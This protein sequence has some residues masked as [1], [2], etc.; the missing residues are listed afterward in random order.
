LSDPLAI[1]V[2]DRFG[3]QRL[4]LS[5]DP[6]TQTWR[7]TDEACRL[8]VADIVVT[9]QNPSWE[10]TSA[11]SKVLNQDV[12]A[13]PSGA[14]MSVLFC[15]PDESHWLVGWRLAGMPGEAALSVEPS[16]SDA[17]VMVEGRVRLGDDS[18]CCRVTPNADAD[19]IVFTADGPVSNR[20]FNALFSR[21]LDAAFEA[22]A[23]TAWLAPTERGHRLRAEAP[24]GHAIVLSLQEHFFR[25]V[26]PYYKPIDKSRFSRPAN[27]W[28][29]YYCLFEDPDEDTVLRIADF[30]EEHLVPFG[31][32]YFSVE[33]WQANHLQVLVQPNYWSVDHRKFPHGVKWLMDEIRARGLK[34][35][36]WAV[37]FG[38]GDETFHAMRPEIFLH[39]AEGKPLENWSGRYILDP[40]QTDA[41]ENMRRYVRYLAKEFGAEYLKLDG[42]SHWAA[43]HYSEAFY[44]QD[45]VKA[46]FRQPA[47][48]PYRDCLLNLRDAMGEETFFLACGGDYDGAVVGVANAARISSDV[49][50]AGQTTSWG[51]VTRSV[52]EAVKQ[53]WYHNI[54]WYN[55]PDIVALR[56][57]LTVD[58][59]RAWC[60]AFA[61]MGLL[62]FDSDILPDMDMPR[63][64]TLQRTIP[65]VD[66]RPGQLYP[67]QMGN[68]IDLKI[69]RP[70]GEWD[71]IG[72]F[73]WRDGQDAGDETIIVRMEDLGLEPAEQYVAFEYWTDALI[74]VVQ[75][76]FD[77]IVPPHCCRAVALHKLTGT[78]QVVST[79]RHVTQDGV[80]LEDVRWDD[81]GQRLTG[82]SNVVGGHPYEIRVFVPDGFSVEGAFAYGAQAT[83]T[84]DGRLARVVIESQVSAGVRWEVRF[85]STAGSRG[86]S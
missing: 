20:R 71:V 13:E 4:T 79:N 3:K 86:D 59:G 40:T 32:E 56:E 64:E 65:V 51:T 25:R 5:F 54:V 19:R 29:S 74:G 23:D 80:S 60:T 81:E 45:H 61:L 43:P 82:V 72:V 62:L 17:R 41:K 8:E 11:E 44:R 2:A 70:F 9:L 10:A 7:L 12:Q 55:D 76:S 53:L 85:A 18:F 22:H 50:Y 48:N 84:Q 37:P 78:P 30:A 15:A 6:E 21:N 42:L 28:L 63:I 46:C 57:P 36:L 49:F 68:I 14:R 33:M 77:V 34:P 66:A 31:M 35:G 39:D 16:G 1:H 38:T 27:G 47:E 67:I 75:E 73:N 83:V 26:C 52:R 69:A 58:M 24:V